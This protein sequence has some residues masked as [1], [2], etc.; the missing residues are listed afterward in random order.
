MKLKFHDHETPNI[1]YT[2]NYLDELMQNLKIVIEKDE[3]EFNH[4]VKHTQELLT[5]FSLNKNKI[6]KLK[7]SK[8]V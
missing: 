5:V 1:K 6:K 7:K 2:N 3:E 8:A 4:I